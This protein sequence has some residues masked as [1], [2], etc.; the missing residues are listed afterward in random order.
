MNLAS[1]ATGAAER[2]DLPDPVLRAAIAAMVARTARALDRD[3]RTARALDRDARTA[4]AADAAFAASMR[5]RP[6]ALHAD[7]A[8]AQHYEVPAEFF[9]YVLGP[10]RKYSSCL[11]ATGAETLDQAELAALRASAD[12]AGIADGQR[13]LEL[14]CGWG[15]LAL[16]MAATLPH[17][18]ITAVSNSASQRAYIEAAAAAAGLR[19]LRIVTADMNHF[20]PAGQFD[21]I[22][23]VE[24]FE[25]MS[26]WRTLLGRVRDWLAPQGRMFLHVFTHRTSPYRFDHEHGGDWIARYFFTGGIMPSHTLVHQFADILHVEAERTWSGTHYAR[27]ALHW[28]DNFDRNR[29]AIDVVLG[30]VYGGEAAIWGRRWRLFFLAVAGLFGHA[31]GD[32]WGVSQY[33][34]RD[35]KE[36]L[37]F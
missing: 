16:F 9:G 11:Y 25:H 21:R 8:N 35:S 6:V 13:I 33:R 5:D 26:N 7:A 2:M 22:V 1:L 19:N 28:L 18:E 14:G 20:A 30:D 12:F 23:S 32:V 24:M 29:A 27:T 34:L 36:G 4:G 17:A 37:L 10:R 15:S 31:G 3:A